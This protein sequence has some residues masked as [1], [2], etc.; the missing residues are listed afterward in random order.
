MI[1]ALKSRRHVRLDEI[2]D[3]RKMFLSK[4]SKFRLEWCLLISSSLADNCAIRFK[5]DSWMISMTSKYGVQ[6]NVAK[7]PVPFTA[8]RT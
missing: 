2:W 7:F 4:R 3:R 5:R 1:V 6:V 8:A